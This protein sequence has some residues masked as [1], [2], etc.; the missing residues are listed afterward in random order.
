ML[1]YRNLQRIGNQ[2][3]LMLLLILFA[4]S[5]YVQLVWHDLPCPLCLLQRIAFCAIGVAIVFNLNIEIRARHYGLM[6]LAA[7]FG[8][9]TATRQILL[10][11]LPN[12]PGFGP[13]IMGLHIYSWS[14]LLFMAVLILSAIALLLDKGFH[15]AVSS[16]ITTALTVIFL[17]FVGLNAVSTLLECGLTEC[18]DNPT[19]YKLLE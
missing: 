2:I 4:V 5:F 18:P 8:L 19:H 9:I 1:T 13:P 3:G 16:K 10:H 15:K 11:I 12:D 7:L 6:I 14:A 17:L